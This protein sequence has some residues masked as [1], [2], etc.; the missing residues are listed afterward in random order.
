MLKRSHILLR[1]KNS[2][3]T[4]RRRSISVHTVPTTLVAEMTGKHMNYAIMNDRL[5][6]HVRSA[7]GTLTL[8]LRSR[9]IFVEHIDRKNVHILGPR[10]RVWMRQKGEPP[11]VAEFVVHCF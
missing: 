3:S 4:N 5:A 1:D 10:P 11:G 8:K 9:Y 6:T 2:R 7:I